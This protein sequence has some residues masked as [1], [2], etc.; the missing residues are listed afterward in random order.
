MPAKR[1]SAVLLHQ[2]RLQRCLRQAVLTKYLKAILRQ[3]KQLFLDV[4][5][6]LCCSHAA[7]HS[8]F[9]GGRVGA[10]DVVSTGG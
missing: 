10:F 1:A 5:E 8:T 4:R 2:V 6:I 3:R 7:A 9:Q